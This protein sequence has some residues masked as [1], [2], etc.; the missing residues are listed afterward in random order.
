MPK[1][2]LHFS[3]TFTLWHCIL[4]VFVWG[5]TLP[6]VVTSPPSLF[7]FHVF[8][9]HLCMYLA[10]FWQIFFASLFSHRFLFCPTIDFYGTHLLS[11]FCS[12]FF[13]NRVC[14]FKI[15]TKNSI[16]TSSMFFYPSQKK[17]SEFLQKKNECDETVQWYIFY[18]RTSAKVRGPML[19]SISKSRKSWRFS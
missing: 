12:L 13:S 11:P 8:F 1:S 18:F 7:C 6:L 15:L 3:P 19:W 4:N 5:T 14:S 10:R 9:Q 2:N 16:N 17:K